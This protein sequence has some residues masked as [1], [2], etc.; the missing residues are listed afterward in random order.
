MIYWK[1]VNVRLEE[2]SYFEVLDFIVN[3]QGLGNPWITLRGSGNT[4][5]V[6]PQ[7][8]QGFTEFNH[9]QEVDF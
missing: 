1:I 6:V 7:E 3:T 9:P 4:L 8:T 2:I 5:Q